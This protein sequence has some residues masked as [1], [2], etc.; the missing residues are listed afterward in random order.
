MKQLILRWTRII[1]LVYCTAGIALYYLQEKLLFHP[2]VLAANAA[3]S[4][5]AP[6]EEFFLP[7]NETDSISVV[8]FLHENNFKGAVVYYHGNRENINH[9]AA[10]AANFTKNGYD[11]WMMDYAGFGKSTG[12]L[13]ERKLYDDA[14]QV[15]KLVNSKYRYCQL[16]C[17][18]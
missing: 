15:F 14:M 4:F 5:N 7:L 13:S 6:H 2:T 3:F 10:F 18:Q 1:L 8:K 12:K 11:V 9:Y 16:C 17:R